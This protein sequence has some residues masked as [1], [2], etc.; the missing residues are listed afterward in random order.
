MIEPL[1]RAV[2]F[3]ATTDLMRLQVFAFHSE[4]SL[5]LASNGHFLWGEIKVTAIVAGSA[6]EDAWKQETRVLVPLDPTSNLEAAAAN[7]FAAQPCSALKTS[8]F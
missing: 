6:G 3:F 8:F 7:L 4:M 1:V 5:S 2:M